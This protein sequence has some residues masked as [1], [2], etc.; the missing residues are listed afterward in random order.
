LVNSTANSLAIGFN[1][2][3]P[4]LFVGP[5]SGVGAYG[6]VGIGT[7]SPAFRLS[8][9]NDGG[10]IASGIEG[11]G[12]TLPTFSN[13]TQLVW[14]PSHATLLVGAGSYSE[15]T[16]GTYCFA[17]GK[18]QTVVGEAS[19][20]LGE[21]DQS[22][23][24]YAI[25]IGDNNDVQ[26]YGA[27]IGSG[28]N[29]AGSHS[30]AFG[31][32][33]NAGLTGA[34]VIGSGID[35]SHQLTNSIT[36]SIALGASSTVPALFI[37]G[38]NGTSGS[39]GNVGIGTG[40]TSTL[41][42][43]LVVQGQTNDATTTALNVT[44]NTPTSLLYVQDDGKVGI[45]TNSPGQ[46][47][48]V[49]GN[50][51]ISSNGGAANQL[52]F[53]NP[54][55]TFTTTFKAGAQASNIDYTLPVAPATSNKNSVLLN[56]G[57][58]TLSWAL[59]NTTSGSVLG[60]GQ[61]MQ[62]AVWDAVNSITGY[63]NLW[64]DNTNQFMGIGTGSPSQTLEV[65]G[66]TLISSTGNSPHQ[67]QLQGT[68]TGVTT[69]QAG[70]Q[71]TTDINY[72]LPA[73]L[74]S[75][76]DA[77]LLSTTTGGLSWSTT[78]GL[79]GSSGGGGSATQIAFWNSSSS[80]TGTDNLWWDNTDSY[81]GI[82]TN[83][84]LYQIDVRGV[85]LSANDIN[86]INNEVTEV[87]SATPLYQSYRLASSYNN[88]DHSW[89][90]EHMSVNDANSSAG[91]NWALP[92]G[93][94]IFHTDPTVDTKPHSYFSINK[95]GG[96]NIGD[97]EYNTGTSSNV[98]FSFAY[99]AYAD[100]VPGGYLCVQLGIGVGNQSPQSG[101]GLDVSEPSITRGGTGNTGLFV[102]DNGDVAIQPASTDVS[103]SNEGSTQHVVGT[104]P[105]NFNTDYALTIN[106]A[107]ANGANKSGALYIDGSN[108]TN[109]IVY[110]NGS[111]AV[112]APDALDVTG[113][114]K[115]NGLGVA[116]D[117]AFKKD[118]I[119]ID[120]ALE[121]IAKLRGVQ[122][123]WRRDE[124]PKMNF[125]D[126]RNIGL[127]AEEVEKVVPEVVDTGMDG[128]EAIEYQNLVALL[129]EGIKTQEQKI[130]SVQVTTAQ[131][132]QTISQQTNTINDLTNRITQ[133]ETEFQQL[134][135][136]QASNGGAQP[137]GQ[138][139]ISTTLQIVP[140]PFTNSTSINY[141]LSSAM[142]NAQIIISNAGN[143]T[144]VASFSIANKTSGSIVLDGSN[145]APGTYRCNIV[146]NGQV[147]GS[148]NIVLIK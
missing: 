84:P 21:N 23:G 13:S 129:V 42:S 16:V 92:D 68:S 139:Q 64:W 141:S 145:L 117:R 15:S 77:V 96:V 19:V 80:L 54:A 109:T 38:G 36:N 89:D 49:K 146:A 40:T 138:A 137:N 8:L 130:D 112:G 147:Y 60:T 114:V 75:I 18:S 59:L 62:I 101:F 41:G 29:T 104:A 144:P 123:N 97:G 4:T 99:N 102:T 37:L 69:F 91:F 115:V 61:Q 132:Q 27:A 98:P 126:R 78:K 9:D 73:A 148:Q 128:Y 53:Q 103:S 55:G 50:A 52:Q 67:L 33:C 28:N 56:D 76:D 70:A 25:T 10:I 134:K 105:N 135:N 11:S 88:N 24:S 131:Q 63:P 7:T 2:T 30:Y 48:E 35:A 107:P 26:E 100:N 1:S 51:L 58:G 34:T 142:A 125:R 106:S 14:C 81:L 140:N 111:T 136:A 74:P 119:T 87:S 82:G 46:T 90:I 124:F 5:S 110:I 43:E 116:S 133:L 85:N 44:N 6:N 20:A 17:A 108:S 83:N 95:N 94:V 143:G 32:F 71:G 121:K 47:L 57:S 65:K 86:T 66:N 3:V 79:T 39:M 72:T 22:L 120:S 113:T 93:L 12:A 118:I 45:G 31:A 122:Y 127:I